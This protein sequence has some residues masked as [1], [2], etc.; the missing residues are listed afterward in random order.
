MESSQEDGGDFPSLNGTVP[1]LKET[2]TLTIDILSIVMT[3][4]LDG[5]ENRDRNRSLV[6]KI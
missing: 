3:S 1:Y 4:I 2:G 6:K 5:V